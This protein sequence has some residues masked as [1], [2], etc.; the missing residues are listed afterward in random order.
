MALSWQPKEM[1]HA[2]SRVNTPLPLAATPSA[3][4]A[5]SR[6]FCFTRWRRRLDHRGCSHSVS[7]ASEHATRPRTRRGNDN[8]GGRIRIFPHLSAAATT[9]QGWALAEQG[10][11]AA[12]VGQLQRGLEVEHAIGKMIRRPYYLTLLV[13]AYWKA[14]QVEEAWWALTE[15]LAL[16]DTT[17][18]RWWEAEIQRLKG[19]LRG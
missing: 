11:I 12:G 8:L 10:Q 14:G 18:E 3:L 17:G 9:L 1:P 13:A 19:E 7:A 16:V 4:G 5:L 2:K 6:A 15:A